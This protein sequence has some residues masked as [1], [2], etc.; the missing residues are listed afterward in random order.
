MS[1]STLK[2]TE[3]EKSI[4]F[5]EVIEPSQKIMERIGKFRIDV[6][7][8]ET[9]VNHALFP[10]GIW[11]ES[12]DYEARHWI[13]IDLS[14]RESQ[15]IPSI[16]EFETNN[17]LKIVGV[18][19]LSVHGDLQSNP[20]GYL[21]IQN[22]LEHLVQPPY[23]HLCKLVVHNDYRGFG[24]GKQLNERRLVMAK[25]L[26][27]KSMLVTASPQNKNILLKFGFQDSNILE[28]FPN[29]PHFPFHLM[30]CNF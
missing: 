3:K 9:E 26:G 25:H 16:E 5:L 11:I 13:A 4:Y 28:V 22:H 12:I 6:W 20:D 2:D 14:N 27:A 21:L 30:Y 23:G 15:I 1:S 7:K 29:R 19:R 10:D 8:E 17:D 24:I 18:A